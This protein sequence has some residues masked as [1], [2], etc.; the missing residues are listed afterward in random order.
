MS[1]R[2]VHNTVVSVTQR[3][4]Q[5]VYLARLQHLHGFLMKAVLRGR[6]A[7]HRDCLIYDVQGLFRCLKWRI[8][9]GVLHQILRNI[10]SLTLLTKGTS[11]L[12]QR[13][14]STL[15][16]LQKMNGIRKAALYARTKPAITSLYVAQLERVLSRN[17]QAAVIVESSD[18]ADCAN[19]DA[20]GVWW[21]TPRPPG[22]EA[23]QSLPRQ[24]VELPIGKNCCHTCGVVTDSGQCRSCGT[25]RCARYCSRACQETHWR[26]HKQVCKQMLKRSTAFRLVQTTMQ[27]KSDYQADATIEKLV[28]A[29]VVG[30]ELQ[31]TSM[32]ADV[33]SFPSWFVRSG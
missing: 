23:I 19:T 24:M 18:S 28:H 8:L 21:Q 17:S 33:G 1:R 13:E 15:K 20:G 5:H 12:L 29:Q 16:A 2:V 30:V 7:K 26:Q 3:W 6:W 10:Y 14:R 4:E 9:L 11:P 25:C 31:K 32:D 22:Y 27:Q